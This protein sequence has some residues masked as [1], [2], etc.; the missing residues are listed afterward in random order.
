MLAQLPLVTTELQSDFM[1][2]SDAYSSFIAVDQ[3]LAA[4]V[5]SFGL[6][7]GTQ[8]ADTP[9]L[10]HSLEVLKRA[11]QYWKSRGPLSFV[12][13]LGN[14]LSATN[15]TGQQWPALHSF[16]EARRNGN[17]CKQWHLTP[18]AHDLSCFGASQL[19]A[20]VMPCRAGDGL[21]YAFSPAAGW[22]VLV[23]DSYDVSLLAHEPGSDAHTATLGLLQTAN[24]NPPG[25]PDPLAGLEG[26]ARRWGPSG[27]GL[28]AVQLSWFGAQLEAASR[29]NERVIVLCHLSCLPAAARPEGLLYNFAEAQAIV[30]AH[31][32]TVAAWISGADGDGGYARDAHGVHH[33]TP[34]AA[35]GCAINSDAYG[36]V[37]VYRP[38]Q[39]AHGR[40]RARN[41]LGS[42][43]WPELDLPQGQARRRGAAGTRGPLRPLPGALPDVCA[44]RHLRLRAALARPQNAHLQRRRRRGGGGRGLRRPRRRPTTGRPPR[45]PRPP[46]PPPSSRPR[47][48]PRRP[49]LPPRRSG[50]EKAPPE[51]RAS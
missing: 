39:A 46:L 29:G 25:A 28:G 45:P 18:G 2:E 24:P 4:P 27:G 44:H 11:V 20:S 13:H 10:R 50:R 16:D 12:A 5:Y 42:Q 7:A 26:E 31:P 1:M 3:E 36:S 51:R 22:R 48:P 43:V 17:D 19:A 40:P 47:L 14:A 23:L 32:A 33:L 21:Y 41:L 38:P 6:I 30:D 35:A 9:E 49:R 15:E 8:Y 34:A 37:E